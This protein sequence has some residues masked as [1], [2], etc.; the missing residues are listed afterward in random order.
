MASLS[1]LDPITMVSSG[2][3]EAKP[4]SMSSSGSFSDTWYS[5]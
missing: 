4:S 3:I 1:G 5:Q 2:A